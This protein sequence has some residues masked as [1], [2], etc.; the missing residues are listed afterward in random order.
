MIGDLSAMIDG[1]RCD[2]LSSR[3]VNA[4]RTDDAQPATEASPKLG[5]G[6]RI[7]AVA[8]KGNSFFSI[9]RLTGDHNS[10]T[11]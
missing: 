7:K 5:Y 1:D 8:K 10:V 9:N 11:F 2:Q 6:I 4:S 3:Q